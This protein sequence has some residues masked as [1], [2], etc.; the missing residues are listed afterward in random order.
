MP[1]LRCREAQ[2][3]SPA[4]VITPQMRYGGTIEVKKSMEEKLADTMRKAREGDPTFWRHSL[5]DA[6]V[7]LLEA[8]ESVTI[9]SLIAKLE[10]SGDG[11]SVVLKREV[12]Q[13]AI[14]RLRQ[15]VVKQD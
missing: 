13:A 12:S 5:A 10:A 14:E 15:I 11:P 9:E 6:T 2:Q 3:R 8:G 7:S 1:R 4:P